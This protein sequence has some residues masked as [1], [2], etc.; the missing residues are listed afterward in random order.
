MALPIDNPLICDVPTHTQLDL[1]FDSSGA[2]ALVVNHNVSPCM[3]LT[4]VDE[5]DSDLG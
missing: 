3:L 2:A 4:L 1:V 5:Q